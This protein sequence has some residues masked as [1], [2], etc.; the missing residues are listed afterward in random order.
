MRELVHYRSFV[1]EPLVHPVTRAYSVI[2]LQ[3]FQGFR[4]CLM[5]GLLKTGY[6]TTKGIGFTYQEEF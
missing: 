1:D 5:S 4:N 3:P 2:F 6:S